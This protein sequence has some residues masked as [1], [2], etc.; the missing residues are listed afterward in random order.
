M[1]IDVVRIKYLILALFFEITRSIIRCF[2]GYCSN[3]VQNMDKYSKNRILEK[4]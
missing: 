2:G 3:F 4:Y 1:L